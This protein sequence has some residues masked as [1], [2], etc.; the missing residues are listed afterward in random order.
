MSFDKAAYNKA[1]NR[2]RYAGISFRI[3]KETEK[4]IAEALREQSNIKEY[5]C[6]LIRADVKRKQRRG[7]MADEP[8]G[9]EDPQGHPA[10]SVRGGGDGRFQ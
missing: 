1:Y 2:E 9:R 7:R 6:R 10:L 8:R 4:D 5:I 3:N